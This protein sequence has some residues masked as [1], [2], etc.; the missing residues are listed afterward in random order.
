MVRVFG[1]AK[2]RFREEVVLMVGSAAVVVVAAC[3]CLS[4]HPYPVPEPIPM[5]PDASV[6]VRV[7]P[8]DAI[9]FM[10]LENPHAWSR[11]IVCPVMPAERFADPRSRP[12]VLFGIR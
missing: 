2:D 8:A 5:A 10:C 12:L 1:A 9:P 11:W 4:P 6:Q 7:V 3:F